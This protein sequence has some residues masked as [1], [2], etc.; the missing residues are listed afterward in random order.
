MPKFTRECLR[1]G[2]PSSQQRCIDIA[3]HVEYLKLTWKQ[4]RTLGQEYEVNKDKKY[5]NLGQEIQNEEI[6]IRSVR[7]KKVRC[8]GR[9]VAKWGEDRRPIVPTHSS[10]SRPQI[11]ICSKWR[12]HK[13]TVFDSVVKNV[14]QIE[15]QVLRTLRK[16]LGFIYDITRNSISFEDN[17]SDQAFLLSSVCW[18]VTR[19]LLKVRT[20][21]RLTCQPDRVVCWP[22]LTER[23]AAGLG[24]VRGWHISPPICH[25][26]HSR[27]H[28]D[29]CNTYFL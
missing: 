28:L 1:L 4:N 11:N 12:Q 20:S 25:S 22:E 10:P 29:M 24:W 2:Q 26:L 15:N 16:R 17:L 8:G 13:F 3:L 21:S 23:G 5:E 14:K 9:S 27:Y 6:Q 19:I 7:G 18:D